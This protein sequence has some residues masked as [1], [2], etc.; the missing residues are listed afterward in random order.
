[1]VINCDVTIAGIA[2]NNDANLLL[3]NG[4]HVDLTKHW[5]KYLLCH[6]GCVKRRQTLK[7]KLQQSIL[8]S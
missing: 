4:G 1:M 6:M 8:M 7:Q 3:A 5:A 2:M